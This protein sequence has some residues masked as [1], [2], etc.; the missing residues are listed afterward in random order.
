MSRKETNSRHPGTQQP[1]LQYSQLQGLCPAAALLDTSEHYALQFRV[2]VQSALT[3]PLADWTLHARPRSILKLAC[4]SGT[5][6][7]EHWPHCPLATCLIVVMGVLAAAHSNGGRLWAQHMCG[8]PR[9][10]LAAAQGR[11]TCLLLRLLAHVR[12]R[13][14]HPDCS[15]QIR[16]LT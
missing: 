5:Q 11:F 14:G 10:K 1:L 3:L 7:R 16:R 2:S 15:R 13:K 8:V 6:T 4:T 9:P 12:L